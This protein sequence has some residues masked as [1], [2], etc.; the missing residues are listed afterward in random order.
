MGNIGGSFNMT[1]NSQKTLENI[2]TTLE[3]NLL[4]I[5]IKS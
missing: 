3:R 2:K 1:A 5:Q 4:D